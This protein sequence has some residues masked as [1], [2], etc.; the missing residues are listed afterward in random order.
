MKYTEMELYRYGYRAVVCNTVEISN[1][2]EEMVRLM[3]KNV[4]DGLIVGVDPPNEKILKT[5]EETGCQYGS[6]L[7]R[8]DSG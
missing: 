3:E 1:R 4:L 8:K 2:V 5:S 7:G 6:K